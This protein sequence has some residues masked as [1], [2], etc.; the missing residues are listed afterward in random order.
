LPSDLTI[1]AAQYLVFIDLAIALVTVAV[2]L[3][4]K[5]RIE[6][7]K[8]AF[9]AGIM[10]V[11]SYIFAQIGAAA[12]NDPRPFSLDH[13][14]PLIGHAVDNGFPSD[15]ALLA[16]AVVALVLLADYRFA[17][18]FVILGFLVDWARVG[19]GVHHVIDVVGSSL[20][21][22]LATVIAIPAAI[23]L[24]RFVAP[25]VSRFLSLRPPAPAP[26]SSSLEK[27]KP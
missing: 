4:R 7:I 18:P 10:L 16:A 15:H 9:G 17:L 1:F 2:I 13:I 6:S 26:T 24:T 11:L 27:S 23:Y 8:W 3:Y 25:F 14:R 21:V 5:P 20:F 19:A 12:Y 22:A